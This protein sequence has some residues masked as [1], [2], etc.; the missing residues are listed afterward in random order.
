[1]TSDM[2]H[3]LA[4]VNHGPV[5]RI[6]QDAEALIAS[7]AEWK[8][9]QDL[10]YQGWFTRPWIYQVIILSKEAV[11]TIGFS[12]LPWLRFL[13]VLYWTFRQPAR[14]PSLSHTFDS[15]HNDRY[16]NPILR[17]TAFTTIYTVDF[18]YFS[19]HASCA[20]PMDRIYGMLDLMSLDLGRHSLRNCS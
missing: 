9:I 6:Q 8:F 13:P 4:V 1:M 15:K 7:E 14:I 19:R 5:F 11:V 20:D 2:I 18:L 3:P 16:V 17:S 12:E 10:L